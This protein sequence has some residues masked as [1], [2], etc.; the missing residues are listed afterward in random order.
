MC[1]DLEIIQ[2]NTG[3]ANLQL[4]KKLRWTYGYL[5]VGALNGSSCIKKRER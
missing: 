2:N 3:A 5:L 4:W 1:M